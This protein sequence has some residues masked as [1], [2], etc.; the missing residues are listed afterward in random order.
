MGTFHQ[1]T[2]NRFSTARQEPVGGGQG[3]SVCNNLGY[4]V[5]YSI[6]NDALYNYTKVRK[7]LRPTAN[8]F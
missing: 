1:P 7:F 5:L 3:H 2:A 4:C 8:K 6:T